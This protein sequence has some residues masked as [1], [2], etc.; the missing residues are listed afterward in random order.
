MCYIVSLSYGWIDWIRINKF[1]THSGR[2]THICVGNL[3]IIGSDNDLSPLSAPSHY[4]KRCWNIV[5]WTFRNE[6]QWNFN[7]NSNIFIQEI[8]F[9]N[10][11]CK[12]AYILSRPRWVNIYTYRSYLHLLT[13]RT[14]LLRCRTFKHTLGSIESH[15]SSRSIRISDLFL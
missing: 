7:R 10:V 2:V 1:L 4:L 13:T 9:E 15:I 12:M 11:F 6:L 14:K 3:T 5:N 8:A